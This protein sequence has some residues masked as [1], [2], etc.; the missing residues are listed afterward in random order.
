MSGKRIRE[1]VKNKK[2]RRIKREK[3]RGEELTGAKDHIES[4][5]LASFFDFFHESRRSRRAAQPSVRF[6]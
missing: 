1:R 4:V 5:F 2:G 3:E 6:S